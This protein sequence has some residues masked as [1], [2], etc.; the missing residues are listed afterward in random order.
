MSFRSRGEPRGANRSRRAVAD[1]TPK[2]GFASGRSQSS[3][4][5]PEVRIAVRA[6]RSG[7][8]AS[9]RARYPRRMRVVSLLPSA[10]ELLFAAGAGDRLVGRSHECDHPAG[11]GHVPVLTSARTGGGAAAEIDAEVS[12]ALGKGESLYRLDETAT[13]RTHARRDPDPGPLR[14]LLDRPRHRPG[15]GGVAAQPADRGEPRSQVDLRRLRRPAAGRRGGRAGTRRRGGD[16]AAARPL[17]AG[18]RLRE[19]RGETRRSSEGTGRRP[20]S[21]PPA[22]GTR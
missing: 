11:L 4:P 12:A 2:H 16:G 1:P 6:G 17:L 9:G 20:S 13:R 5:S 18:D 3:R 21:R 19:P 22:G 14:G 8:A 7:A 15:R 10:T